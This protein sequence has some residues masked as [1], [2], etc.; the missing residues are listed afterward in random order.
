VSVLKQKFKKNCAIAAQPNVSGLESFFSVLPN[1]KTAIMVMS[2]KVVR[3]TIIALI[4][5]RI[6]YRFC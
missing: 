6:S 3:N 5:H 1:K 2:V 4:V